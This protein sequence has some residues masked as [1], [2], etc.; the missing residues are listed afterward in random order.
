[1]EVV[2]LHEK[3]S[4]GRT[5]IEKFEA[6]SDVA[7]AF[8]V[9]LLTPDDLG[10]L[11]SG[12]RK[13]LAPRARQNVILELGYFVGKLTRERVCA[14]C[15]NGVERPSDYDGVVYVPLDDGGGWRFELAKELKAAFPFVVLDTAL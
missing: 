14:L 15:V 6:H 13:K 10:M 1:L 2:I 4:K 7:F 3:A 11:A 5:L 12:R 9:V 8:A